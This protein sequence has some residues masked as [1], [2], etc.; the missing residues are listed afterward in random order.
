MEDP[1]FELE[2]S[3]WSSIPLLEIIDPVRTTNEKRGVYRTTVG[4][5]CYYENW[6]KSSTGTKLMLTF[7]SWENESLKV[8]RGDL[9]VA[10]MR[11]QG[12]EVEWRSFNKIEDGIFFLFHLRS[13]SLSRC[14]NRPWNL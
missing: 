5:A 14:C 9:A 10:S 1:T 3:Q 4:P 12:E 11:Y 6:D 13:R 7:E 2:E 8:S